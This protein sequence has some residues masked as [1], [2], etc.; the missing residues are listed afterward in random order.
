MRFRL[1]SSTGVRALV[2]GAV[3][4]LVL[5]AGGLG[6]AERAEAATPYTIELAFKTLY[7]SNV[8]DGGDSQEIYGALSGRTSSTERTFRNFGSWGVSP[9]NCSLDGV[10]WAYGYGQNCLKRTYANETYNFIDTYLCGSSSGQ[11][12]EGVYA[13]SNHRILLTVY[14]GESIRAAIAALDYDTFSPDDTVCKAEK[15][16]G[17]FTEA[18]LKTLSRTEWMSMAYNGEAACTVSFTLKRI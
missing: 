11:T 1:F 17:P 10:S 6:G 9:S 3:L 16:V 4:A 13:K 8:N 12:C 14:P 2:G 15:W 7:F 18:E 5:V